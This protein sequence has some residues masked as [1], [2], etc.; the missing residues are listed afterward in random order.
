M[1]GVLEQL[2]CQNF[3]ST[4]ILVGSFSFL[5]FQNV[6]Y[7]VREPNVMKTLLHV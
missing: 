4:S 7:D 1:V 2:L 5:D 6:C 3:A